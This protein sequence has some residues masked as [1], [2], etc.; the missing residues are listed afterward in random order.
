L[1]ELHKL[2][3]VVFIAISCSEKCIPKYCFS[4]FDLSV[5]MKIFLT[6]LGDGKFQKKMS[7][8]ICFE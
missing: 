4:N 2:S 3:Q 5:Q 7:R 8:N 6:Q 1:L